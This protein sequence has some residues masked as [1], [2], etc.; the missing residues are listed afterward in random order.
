LVIQNI[1]NIL[2]RYAS[3]VATFCISKPV[4][5]L[6]L[7]AG[8]LGGLRAVAFLDTSSMEAAMHDVA[9]VRSRAPRQRHAT[10]IDACFAAVAH[11]LTWLI[12]AIADE[13]RIRRDM[14]QLAAMDD[15][16]LKDI[17]LRRGEIEYRVRYGRDG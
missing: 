9:T 14:R 3:V 10:I 5:V 8:S 6:A 17:G 16:M 15:Q 2:F 4:R 7:P 13:V 1:I 11:A 12:I